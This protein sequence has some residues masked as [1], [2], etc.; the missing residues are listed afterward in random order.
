[1]Y[2][3]YGGYAVALW[4]DNDEGLWYMVLD[5]ASN[6]EIH[7]LADWLEELITV[8][9]NPL[10]GQTNMYA[11]ILEWT[12]R[13]VEWHDLARKYIEEARENEA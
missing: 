13:Q 7:E 5:V 11:D 1:M 3:E 10:V 12:L 4:I 6:M 2:E 8:E 9:Y